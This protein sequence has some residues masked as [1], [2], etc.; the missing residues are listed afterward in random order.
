MTLECTASS[1]ASFTPFSN[2]VQTVARLMLLLQ[3][4]VAFREGP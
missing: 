2:E 4:K 3:A 1:L